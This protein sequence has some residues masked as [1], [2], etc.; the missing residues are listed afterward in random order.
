MITY[1]FNLICY[2]SDTN[3][4][5][6][7]LWNKEGGWERVCILDDFSPRTLPCFPTG[8]SIVPVWNACRSKL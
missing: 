1:K 5:A 7:L 6:V 2:H 8:I 3:L 4:E